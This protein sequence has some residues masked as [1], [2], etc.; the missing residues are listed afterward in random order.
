MF[1]TNTTG[2]GTLCPN[3][4]QR[5][6]IWMLLIV[7]KWTVI[8]LLTLPVWGSLL[9]HV[10][11]VWVKPRLVRQA[12]I[13]ALAQRLIAEHGPDCEHHA[14]IEEDYAWR[15]GNVFEQAVWRRVRRELSRRRV[16][17]ASTGSA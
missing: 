7:L 4:L 17:R 5:R 9:L 8:C 12:D 2:L 1:L 15:R 6:D 3:C 13:A 10:W 14:A 11:E 16:V